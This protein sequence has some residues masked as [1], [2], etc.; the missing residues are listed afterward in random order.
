MTVSITLYINCISKIARIGEKSIGIFI[1]I[2]LSINFLQGD[3][4]GSVAI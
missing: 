1:G 3:K 4:T 2:N